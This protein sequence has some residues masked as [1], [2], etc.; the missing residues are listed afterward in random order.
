LSLSNIWVKRPG[1][2]PIRAETFE[3]LLGRK[4]ARAVRKNEQIAWDAIA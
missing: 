1:T 3:Q 2:G 4:T